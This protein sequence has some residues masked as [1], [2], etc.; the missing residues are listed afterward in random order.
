MTASNAGMG[1]TFNLLEQHPGATSCILSSISI[2]AALFPPA[3][4][5][6]IVGAIL[7]SMGGVFFIQY[8]PDHITVWFAKAVFLAL[9]FNAAFWFIVGQ[10]QKWRTRRSRLR[11]PASGTSSNE[12]GGNLHDGKKCPTPHSRPWTAAEMRA[13][14]T[15]R[16]WRDCEWV[17]ARGGMACDHLRGTEAVVRELGAT[18]RIAILWRPSILL[19]FF[20]PSCLLVSNNL[21]AITSGVR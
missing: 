8:A 10:T 18:C 5:R 12:L 2:I 21:I 16:E 17:R 4:W 20:S 15:E 14:G 19:R 9:V 3:T 13:C 7:A 1:T 11:T 6:K